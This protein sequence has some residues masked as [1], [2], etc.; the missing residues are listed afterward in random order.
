V[1]RSQE[2]SPAGRNIRNVWHVATQSYSEAHFATFPPKLIEP[3]VLAG[4]PP[5][6]CG[7]CGAPWRRVVE[8]K[9]VRELAAAAGHAIRDG[10]RATG[11]EYGQADRDTLSLSNNHGD[12]PQSPEV[13]TVGWEPTCRHNDDT[14]R[15]VVLDPFAGAGTTG[16]VALRHDRAFIGCE[17][18]PAYVE[19][20]RRRI[21]D[22]QPLFNWHSEEQVV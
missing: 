16:L 21:C 3:C 12:I 5:K 22:D 18:S 9:S 7:E 20:A 13:R 10:T 11:P 17:L 14:G 4:S 2:G 8:R 15:S 6:C 1:Q 19:M